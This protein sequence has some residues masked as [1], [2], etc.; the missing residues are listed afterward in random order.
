[1]AIKIDG[2]EHHFPTGLT[3]GEALYKIA[4]CEEGG[5][6]LNRED[7]I[8]IPVK[9]DD[10]LI[11][12]GGEKFVT[13]KPGGIGDNPTLR[14]PVCP[15]FNGEKNI[16]MH[17]AKILAKDLVAEDEKFPQGRLFADLSDK[18]DAR[19][20][21]NVRLI[22]QD[23]DSYIVIP[24]SNENDDDSV[25]IEE[26]TK[27]DRRPPKSGKYRIRIDGEKYSAT[28][29]T[30]TGAAILMLAGKTAK[31][32]GLN[33][34]LKSNERKPIRSDESVDLSRPGIERFETVRI[35]AEQ[36]SSSI[37]LLPEETEYLNANYPERW[38]LLSENSTHGIRI[39]KFPIPDGYLPNA[40][41]LLIIIP[42]G[43]PGAALDMFYF[44]PGLQKTNG[45]NIETI[46]VE[47]H[48][49]HPWQRW[50]RHYQWTPGE[51]NL[52][53]H[54]EF[55]KKRLQTEA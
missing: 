34:K 35:Q 23:E 40:S 11:I 41:D 3:A 50:S 5:L 16:S 14:N 12:H 9:L 29:M 45:K 4:Q 26:C 51:D 39:S 18:M 46:E 24:P 15:K 10:C 2:K 20:A 13:G 1:M 52:I 42:Q 44:S 36:G 53:R 21:D 19:I 54:I 27:H 49:N 30:L 43:Y 33:Q 7:G 22:V 6:Y 48:F 17:H 37:E 25:D 38:I 28:T 55:V 8:D 31:E 32:W 47:Q